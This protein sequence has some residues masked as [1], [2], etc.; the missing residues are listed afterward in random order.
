MSQ[1]LWR[2]KF[3]K[4]KEHFIYIISHV[5]DKKVLRIIIFALREYDKTD[6]KNVLKIIVDELVAEIV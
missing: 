1:I 4:L 6:K 5:D 2:N 3:P